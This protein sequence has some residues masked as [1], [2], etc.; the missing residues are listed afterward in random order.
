MKIFSI[1]ATISIFID[2]A[3]HP[4]MKQLAEAFHGPTAMALH[5]LGTLPL[6]LAVAGVVTAWWFYL[7]QP[8]IPAA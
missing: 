4:A 1:G 7:K 5:S 6:W 8:A 3:A 2:S